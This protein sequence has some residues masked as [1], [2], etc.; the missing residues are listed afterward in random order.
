[1]ALMDAI[2][3]IKLEIGQQQNELR[4][5]KKSNKASIQERML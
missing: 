3:L 4:S 5:L 1:M 2:K